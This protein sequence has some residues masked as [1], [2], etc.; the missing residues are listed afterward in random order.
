MSSNLVQRKMSEVYFTDLRADRKSKSVSSKIARLF[1]AS[2]MDQV[3][4]KGD[5]VA[6]KSHFGEAGSSSFLRPQFVAKV[7]DLVAAK[8]GRPF[9]TDCNTLYL[10]GRTN[11]VDHLMT[12]ARHG[13]FPPVV[14]A[15]LI[16]ADGLTGQDQFEIPVGLKHCKTV[17]VGM[18]AHRADAILCV[19]HVKGHMLSGFGGAIKNLGMG[20][21]SRAGKLEMHNDIR[22]A[23][24]TP[25]CKGCGECAK[26][27]PAGA[28]TLRSRKAKI[29]QKKCFGC[30]E[31]YAACFNKAISPGEWT[32]NDALQERMVEYCYGIT[33]D[34]GEK[35]GYISFLVD[36]TPHC[37][38]SSW[39]DLPIVPDIG[40][41]ASRDIVAIDQA[42]IDMVNAQVG[43]EGSALKKGLEAGSDK[44]RALYGVDWTV[45]L[46]YAEE[47]GLGR[48]KYELVKV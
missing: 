48:R 41:L 32:S 38:C 28:I 1:R 2:G 27:C 10:G 42:A 14:N 21:G 30:G 24:K 13:F 19:S 7:V 22:P 29:D 11:A 34:K 3:F 31:C 47:L 25:L 46:K 23:I 39:S 4:E 6:I 9:L 20:F 26:N 40:I 15:P 5:L 43:L 17:K 36:F 8:G 37:D 33:K 12:A 45:Q 35:L 18:A 16:I 44:L